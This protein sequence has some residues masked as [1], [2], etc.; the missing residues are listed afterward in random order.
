LK[1]SVARKEASAS[2][3]S[4]DPLL[5]QVLSLSRNLFTV[6]GAALLAVAGTIGAMQLIQERVSR[7]VRETRSV[8]R[9]ART[10]YVLS[11]ERQLSLLEPV[12]DPGTLAADSDKRSSRL[13][14]VIDS[15]SGVPAN[16][17]ERKARIS[18]IRS[19]HLSWNN[20]L[21]RQRIPSARVARNGDSERD[22]K[23]ISRR[24]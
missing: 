8:S 14:A 12:R 16:S 3:R 5:H 11:V 2:S 1:D 24:H 23:R 20:G 4:G 21:S 6:A 18:A 10:A 19:A 7:S 13:A 22:R 15:I 9:L 17:G